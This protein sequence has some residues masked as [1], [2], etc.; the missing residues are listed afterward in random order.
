MEQARTA[1]GDGRGVMRRGERIEEEGD[2]PIEEGVELFQDELVDSVVDDDE[3]D[4]DGSE[5]EFL[6]ALC[7]LCADATLNLMGQ[8]PRRANPPS[9]RG[10][11]RPSTR[12]AER[13]GN[14]EENGPNGGKNVEMDDS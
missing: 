14:G 6:A 8:V 13:I 9:P 12:Y 2:G 10:M 11:S 7:W 1:G 4:P 5:V 3:I